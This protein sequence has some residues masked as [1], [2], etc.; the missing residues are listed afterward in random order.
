MKKATISVTTK[1]ISEGGKVKPT[2]PI[3]AFVNTG[4][5][6]ILINRNYPL[7]P[8]ASFGISVDGAVGAFL[9]A[10]VDITSDT[11]FEVSFLDVS[12]ADFISGRE[13]GTGHLVETFITYK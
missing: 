4:S 9:L 3:W 5:A 2:A 11:E 8:G 1:Q 13:L 10:G 12:K 7:L 6:K